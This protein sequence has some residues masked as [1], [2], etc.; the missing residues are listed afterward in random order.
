MLITL[1]F[2]VVYAVSVIGM[3]ERL[4]RII[5]LFAAAEAD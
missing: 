4:L 2:A 5:E 3:C 1:W